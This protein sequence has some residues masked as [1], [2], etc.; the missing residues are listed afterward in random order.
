MHTTDR[1]GPAAARRRPR[2]QWPRQVRRRVPAADVARASGSGAHRRR[3]LQQRDR[4]AAVHRAEHRQEPRSQ[5]AREARRARARRGCR[6]RADGGARARRRELQLRPRAPR[7]GAA[8]ARSRRLAVARA[9]HLEGAI[10]HPEAPVAACRRLPSAPATATVIAVSREASTIRGAAHRARQARLSAA[11]D[12]PASRAPVQATAAR[13]AE[14]HRR[15]RARADMAQA[16]TRNKLLQ[17]AH[18]AGV[19][20]SLQKIADGVDERR[21]P[22]CVAGREVTGERGCRR[23]A[24]AAAAGRSSRRPGGRRGRRERPRSAPPPGRGWSRRQDETRASATIAADPLVGPLLHHAQQLGLQRQ[25]QLA[26][27]V[28]KQR[29]AVGERERAVARGDRAGEGAALMAEK[30]AARQPARSSCS[31]R[32]RARPCRAAGRACGSAARSAPCR[33]RSPR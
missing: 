14:R 16:D 1:C 20:A 11:R 17:V 26:D 13:T 5:P 3:A 19:L 29:A 28:E 27:L 12:R 31:R 8:P 9:M 2:A 23:G 30:L 33:C 10:G 15:S 7:R 25:R 22:A 32:R 24:R 6:P 18:V 21:G 4:R